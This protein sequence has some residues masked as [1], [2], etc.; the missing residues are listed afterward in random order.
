M[1]RLLMLLCFI[2]LNCQAQD[3]VYMS[4]RDRQTDL[5]NHYQSFPDRAAQSMHPYMYVNPSFYGYYAGFYD[6]DNL[7]YYSF[8]E[9]DAMHYYNETPSNYNNATDY[10]N[11]KI[12]ETGPLD[13]E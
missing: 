1:Q 6:N 3:S 9:S 8:Y 7:L 4:A 10:S 2:T 13:D 11:A 5:V 12:E